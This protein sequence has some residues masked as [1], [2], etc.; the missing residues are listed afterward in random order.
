MIEQMF[1]IFSYLK[2][3]KKK[4]EKK[5]AKGTSGQFWKE[6]EKPTVCVCIYTHRHTFLFDFN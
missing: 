1:K 6:V 5:A 4:K 3:K 2:K